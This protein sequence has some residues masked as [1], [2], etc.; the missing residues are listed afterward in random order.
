MLLGGQQ[1]VSCTRKMLGYGK[2]SF[3]RKDAEQS[4]S[5]NL[6]RS[7]IFW[8]VS[9]HLNGSASNG[10]IC[11]RLGLHIVSSGRFPAYR[12]PA[13]LGHLLSVSFINEAQYW[14]RTFSGASKLNRE[15]VPTAFA[16]RIFTSGP[17]GAASVKLK[18]D[19]EN[20]RSQPLFLK[21]GMFE[22]QLSQN[23]F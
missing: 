5:D 19:S 9:R 12:G 23:Q 2:N 15:Q 1:Q 6:Q 10:A 4:D 16:P 17:S 11:L 14:Q 3:R 21:R 20:W 7:W 13:Q 8:I 22:S 18:N